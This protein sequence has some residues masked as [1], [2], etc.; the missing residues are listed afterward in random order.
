MSSLRKY[1]S[2][3]VNQSASLSKS[4]PN[5]RDN[6][7]EVFFYQFS[8]DLFC[9]VDNIGRLVH[10]NPAWSNSVGWS[11]SHLQSK[12]IYFFI[13]P[14]DSNG[15]KDYLASLG[16]GCTAASFE[17]R[18]R[19]FGG[20]YIWL[21]W[22]AYKL[23]DDDS[24]FIIASDIRKQKSLEK[25]VLKSAD[26]ER[27][28]LGSE[29]HDTV[30]QSLVGVAAMCSS[31]KIKILEGR[32]E[33]SIDTTNEIIALVKDLSMQTRNLSHEFYA[34]SVF[35]TDIAQLINS[36]ALRVQDTFKINCVVSINGKLPTLANKYKHHMLRI[37][38]ESV[39]NSIVHG[40]SKNIKIKLISISGGVILVVT[41]DGRG[42]ENT[43]LR[44]NGI[45]MNILNYRARLIGANLQV[46]QRKKRGTKVQ[47]RIPIL[48][49]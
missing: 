25:E 28:R 41:D 5:I 12:S 20:N 43:I 37:V 14:Q 6:S 13:H 44:S 39:N 17:V 47:C 19:C 48:V 10:L 33:E 45:G 23:S 26:W 29:L 49:S 38:Q 34:P 4:N 3:G 18:F 35:N 36:V 32:S 1:T 24:V 27:Q 46:S 31:L 42:F 7:K 9:E 40:G 30:C 16:E 21:S 11:L 22:S 15:F 8:K 2:V